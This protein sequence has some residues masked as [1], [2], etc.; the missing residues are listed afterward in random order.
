[1]LYDV[2]GK[3]NCGNIVILYIVQ[4]NGGVVILLIDQNQ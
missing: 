4:T 3:E 2:G 1:M